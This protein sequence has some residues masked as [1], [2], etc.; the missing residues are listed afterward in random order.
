MMQATDFGNLQDPARLGELEGPDVR[1]ILVESEVRARLVMVAE[2][3]GQDAAQVSFTED[4]NVIETL[5]PYRADEAFRE[6]ILPGAYWSGMALATAG[7]PAHGAA[8]PGP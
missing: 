7:V 8:G 2:V 3:S 5:S 4:E 1:R 6:G